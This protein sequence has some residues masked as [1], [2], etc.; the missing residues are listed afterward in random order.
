MGIVLREDIVKWAG[1]YDSKGSLPY[2]VSRLVGA[3][4]PFGTKVDLPCGSAAYMGGW[5]GVVICP[6]EA[7]YF[8]QGTTLI[9]FGTEV[10]CKG[11]ADDDYEKRKAD[12]LGYDPK[13]CVFLFITPRTW[14]A[15]KK[16]ADTRKTEGFWKDVKAYDATDL[17]QWLDIAHATDRWFAAQVKNFP[18]D[19]IMTAEEFWEEWAIGPNGINLTPQVITAG[20]EYE[21]EQLLNILEGPAV[22]KAVK[23]ATKYEAIAFIIAVAK[24]SLEHHCERFFSKSLIID[25]EGNFRGIRINNK[26]PLNLIP[27]F[28]DVQ[29]L[30]A[31]VSRNHHVLVPLGGDDNFNQETITLPT[32]DRDGQIN[33]LI[34]S[35]V[36]REDAEKF[37]REAGRNITIVKKLAGFPYKKAKWATTENVREIIPALL[38]GRWNEKFKGDIELVE[39]LSSQN[40]NDYLAT[41]NRWKEL[42][43]SPIL[44]IGETWRL[45]SP[46]DLWTNFFTTLT[47]ND[48]DNLQGCFLETYKSGNP[49]VEPE[50]KNDFVAMHN[51]QKKYSSWSREGLAQSLIL[52]S[53]VAE[54]L[55]MPGVSNGQL[56]VDNIV[57]NI[58]KDA[59]GEL[60][61]SFNQEI[62]LLSEASPTSFMSASLDSLSKP[63]PEIMSM[64]TETDGFLHP[65][66]NHTGLLWGLE[67]L[68]WEPAYLKEAADILLQLSE[69]DPGGK[70]SN[71]PINSLVEIFKA[72]HYQTLAPFD[73]RMDILKTIT[74]KHKEAGWNLLI[75]LL[76]EYR[77]IAHPTHKM[78]WRIFDKNTNIRHTHQDAWKT[79]SFVVDLLIS[80]F[81]ATEERV[82]QLLS[83]VDTLSSDDR[84]KVLA[85]TKKTIEHKTFAGESIRDSLR[86]ILNKHRSYPDTD[87]ALHENDLNLIEELYNM[88][89]PVDLVQ[90][91]VW[92]FNEHWPDFPEGSRDEEG[93]LKLSHEKQQE[94]ID[95]ARLDAVKNFLSTFG[96]E[97]TIALKDQIKQPGTFGDALAKIV[98]S[99]EDILKLCRSINDNDSDTWLFQSFIYRKSVTE[100]LE[101]IKDLVLI[102][103]K[104]GYDDKVTANIL[105]P[106]YQ[107]TELW[108][109][110]A[111]L[112]ETIRNIYWTKMRPYFYQLSQ[113]E[114]TYGIEQLLNYRRFATAIDLCSH[115]PKDLSSEL[116]MRVLERAAT[117]QTTDIR[118]ARGYEIQHIFEELDTR[119]D[120]DAA[121]M[122]RLEW[123][124]LHVLSSYGSRRAP[125][126]LEKELASN[127]A[128]FVEVLK[129]VFKPEEGSSIE[130]PITDVDQEVLENRARQGW[131]LF[132]SW[133]QI[134]GMAGDHSI[135]ELFL[136]QWVDSA[137]KLAAE[138]GR[139]TMADIQIGQVLAKYPENIPSWPNDA[140]FRLLERINSDPMKRNYSAGLFNKRGSSSRGPFDGGNIERGHAA[141]FKDLADKTKGSYPNISAIFRNMENNYLADAKRMDEEAERDKLE[142]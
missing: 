66:S 49:V 81:D 137:R 70:L 105:I 133:S 54:G 9:E 33:G 5:D 60:W 30:Y 42:E 97:G 50:D 19:G 118:G 102:L 4:T 82:S 44:Q 134:P 28:D 98:S 35:G 24:Q 124:Y 20:R 138:A 84:E 141:Y 14:R 131:K 15:K 58:F 3:T 85:W 128:S 116:I 114:K 94:R 113:K 65:S 125:K 69:R 115:F 61:S 67:G 126:G 48:F 37:S 34:A 74:T 80:E 104:D 31:A 107:N 86:K 96:L 139:Q 52:V 12:P 46:L 103:I 23:A 7:P 47:K 120:L 53:R 32:L 43:E 62:P 119:T 76:P 36:S 56:W 73:Q 75:S 16:W 72:W 38:L 87:W 117:E 40:Y 109:F 1:S 6:E 25:T 127:P 121:K 11:K 27:R 77:G 92:L 41:L 39:K 63:D 59:S 13:E 110:I 71:R 90:K 22:I 112:K 83:N 100:G 64:F 2:L 135:D 79:Y 57:A 130:E 93:D 140:I 78:R 18:F 21:V 10:N 45:V 132:H 123:L 108:E 101:W 17:A 29:P 51:R 106:V 8:T 111:S 142:Y 88:I 91:Y 89:Q 68:A 95:E 26:N 99:K 122:I 129:W 136:N 55:K